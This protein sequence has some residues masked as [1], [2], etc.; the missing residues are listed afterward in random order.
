M[1]KVMD[2]KV[3]GPLNKSDIDKNRLKYLFMSTAEYT[4]TSLKGNIF[5]NSFCAKFPHCGR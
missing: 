4:M 1:H 2:F 5:K 3:A